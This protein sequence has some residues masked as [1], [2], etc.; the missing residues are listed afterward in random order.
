MKQY[1]QPY[2][3]AAAASTEAHTLVKAQTLATADRA[4]QLQINQLI[5]LTE[6]QAR[7][8]H[9]LQ[10]DLDQVRAWIVKQA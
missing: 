10:A 1:Q 6:A 4:Q 2:T 7:Q 5:N 8:I 3:T 9:R